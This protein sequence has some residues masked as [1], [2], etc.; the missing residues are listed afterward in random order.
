[1]KMMLRHKHIVTVPVIALLGLVCYFNALHNGFVWDDKSLVLDNQYIKDFSHIPDIFTKNLYQGT[2]GEQSNF[3]RPLQNILLL[4]SYQFWKTNS[5]GYHLLNVLL[6]IVNAIL[7]YVVVSR[8]FKDRIIPS[9]TSL[10][11]VSHPIHTQAVTYISGAADL[12]ATFFILLSLYYFIRSANDT[13]SNSN[14]V[15]SLV[16]FVLALL[17]KEFSVVYPLMLLGYV[18]AFVESGKKKKIFKNT[19]PFFILTLAY[20]VLRYFLGL[21]EII[22]AENVSFYS[23]TL[24]FF[25]AFIKY[26]RL[27]IFPFP[28]HPERM[29]VYADSIRNAYVAM[30]FVAFLSF[31]FLIF[32]TYNKSKNVFF[33]L[34]WF[35]IAIIPFSNVFIPINAQMADHWLYFPSIGLFILLSLALDNLRTRLNMQKRRSLYFLIF[36]IITL[37][38][39]LTIRQNRF[40]R[41]EE[42][43]YNHILQ[44]SPKSARIHYNLGDLYR[45]RGQFDGAIVQYKMALD[46]NPGY[47]WA[48]N[49]LGNL[50]DEIGEHEKA[51]EEFKKSVKIKP[52]YIA[53]N[54]LGITHYNRGLWL[55]AIKQYNKAIELNPQAAKPY[56]N[57]GNAY[58]KLEKLNEAKK[59]WKKA[60]QINPALKHI[61]E[62]LKAL[63]RTEK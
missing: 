47:I 23:R 52:N 11:F 62:N 40:W 51:I 43:L 31:L 3:Y 56:L 12:L 22:Q 36:V 26:I 49:N 48:H 55:L 2:E 38:S 8:L 16:L 6:H 19:Y 35:I 63:E 54:S 61:E 45:Q 18:Y 33:C 15:I 1:M 9:L 4:F 39:S 44:Y 25:V 29:L 17:S 5:F 30:S 21:N 50:Y 42:T 24:T 53:Y 28:L 34:A 46:I 7:V 14:Y 32:K 13:Q 60:L 41:N 58:Y 57:L 37:Y 59:A 27:F 20:L 10:F